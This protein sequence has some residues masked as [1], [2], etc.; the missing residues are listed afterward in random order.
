VN[1]SPGIIRVQRRRVGTFD[2]LGIVSVVVFCLVLAVD[3]GEF[4]WSGQEVDLELAPGDLE[5]GFRPG[6]TWYGLY[7]GD[8]KIGFSRLERRRRGD[9]FA[10]RSRTVLEMV[11][12]GNRQQMT[13]HVEAELDSGMVL[14][15][16]DVD[17]VSDLVTVEAEGRWQ[18]GE[19]AVDVRTAGLEEH[20]TVPFDRPPALDANV[21]SL[22]MRNQ[23]E[24]GDRFAFPYFDPMT[25]TTRTLEI[26]YQGIDEVAVVDAKVEA[27]RLRQLVAGTTLHAWV[28]DL[29]EV[30]RQELPLGVV[31]V[32]ETEA[33]ATFEFAQ[34]AELGV[35]AGRPLRVPEPQGGGR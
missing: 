25:L 14:R 1:L 3:I 33:E 11:V 15:S 28:N 32:R 31:V 2:L 20:R 8:R 10:V 23:P 34:G 24:P 21:R 22:L 19:L 18:A 26:E 13:A 6:V 17:V 30:L 7:L 9:G 5:T 12:L 27:H 35:E 29:G 4:G 16:F